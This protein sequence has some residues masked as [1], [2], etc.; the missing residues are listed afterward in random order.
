MYVRS[1]KGAW[2]R[3]QIPRLYSSWQGRQQRACLSWTLGFCGSLICRQTKPIYNFW[4]LASSAVAEIQECVCW[5]SLRKQ[6]L[7]VFPPDSQGTLCRDVLKPVLPATSLTVAMILWGKG[8]NLWVRRCGF[9]LSAK[10]VWSPESFFPFL[11]PMYR[12]RWASAWGF[13]VN[14]L[15]SGW[16]LSLAKGKEEMFCTMHHQG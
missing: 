9:V 2:Q 10:A 4:S 15:N 5:E 13:S 12:Y 14:T 6:G 11:P 1:S 8:W 7:I 3:I 16:L